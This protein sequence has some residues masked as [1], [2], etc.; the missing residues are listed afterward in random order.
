MTRDDFYYTLR[1]FPMVAAVRDEA[2]LE[3]ALTMPDIRVVFI[4]FGDICNISALTKK[5]KAKDR[6]PIVHVDLISGFSSREIVID[7]VKQNTKADGIISTKPALINRA[8]KLGLRTIFRIFLIDSISF[9]NA[10]NQ[11]HLV[12]SDFV[13]VLP[14]IMPRIIES[15]KESL[16][17]PIIAGGLI[18]TKKD[19]MDGLNA[20]AIAIST[21]NSKVWEM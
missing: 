2:G 13:E 7:F 8:R 1:D 20:G 21:T 9:D 4:L 11:Q 6:I 5:I 19:V 14:G 18:R 10:Q 3:K 12:N 17:V 16:P 15:L